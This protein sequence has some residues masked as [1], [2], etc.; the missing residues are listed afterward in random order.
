MADTAEI[1]KKNGMP[2]GRIV[3]FASLALNLL[4][5]GLVGGAI[6]RHDRYGD[7]APLRDL[8]YGPFGAALSM[9]DRHVLTRELVG[10]AGDLRVNRDDI[11]RQFA[12][13]LA[14]LRAKPFDPGALQALVGQQRS[15]LEERQ[16]IGQQLL[17]ERIEA[18]SDDERAAFA[19][20]LERNLRR[21]GRDHHD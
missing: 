3:L 5:A 14:A 1:S 11:R 20:R 9:S 7:G 8:G 2:W 15:K 18:M 4:V 21:A 10:R 12:E 13:M 17:L 19:D 16:A 6:L